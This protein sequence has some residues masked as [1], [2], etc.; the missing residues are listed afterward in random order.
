MANILAAQSGN[1]YDTSTWVGELIPNID[2]EVFL[3]NKTITINSDI[4]CLHISN[5]AQHS[6]TAGGSLIITSNASLNVGTLVTSFSSNN[7]PLSSDVRF[8]VSYASGNAT[9]SCHVPSASSVSFGVPIDNT[10][11]VAVLDAS[12]L[13]SFD[14]NDIPSTGIGGRL[15]N[16]ATVESVGAQI[17]AFLP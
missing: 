5:K 15:R 16:C 10:V 3:N 6:A 8:G 4:Y 11:G 13:W 12:T 17:A 14:A 7:F 1:W 2:D 9:G